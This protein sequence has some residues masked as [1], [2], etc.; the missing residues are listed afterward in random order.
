[1]STQPKTPKQPKAKAP[2][3]AKSRKLSQN[4]IFRVRLEN[5]SDLP[6][7]AAIPTLETAAAMDDENQ[8]A[9]GDWYRLCH[10]LRAAGIQEPLKVVKLE[11]GKWGVADGR[12]RRA[13]AVILWA[14]GDQR[15][16]ELP[17][18]EIPAAAAE[19][20][21]LDSL[22]RRMVPGYVIAYMACL[23]HEG[24][25]TA[26]RRGRPSKAIDM[27][28]A[29]T[30]LTIAEETGVPQSVISHC[31][32][33]L[34]HFQDR[35]VDRESDEPR[36][37]AG[38]LDPARVIHAATGRDAT[39]DQPRRPSSYESW[40]PKIKSVSSTVRGFESWPPEARRN[41]AAVLSK[42]VGQWPESFRAM[43]AEAL[44]T[45]TGGAE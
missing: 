11:G 43:L 25:L 16:A 29:V 7:L 45:F 37:L 28:D 35:P 8:G 10:N 42:E 6:E 2:K 34:R 9:A 21:A 40:L 22:H 38:L 27:S 23:K 30:Q 44:T 41:A 36:I 3:K 14:E 19:G 33:A 18:I 26:R 32:S 12:S 13:A 4:D 17:C 20:I 1:M 39:K 15:F 31:V 5:L 24:Q